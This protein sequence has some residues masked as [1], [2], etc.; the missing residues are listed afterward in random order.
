[1]NKKGK[2]LALAMTLTLSVRSDAVDPRRFNRGLLHRSR[3][4]KRTLAWMRAEAK[5]IRQ[6]VPK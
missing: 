4:I 2:L 5:N 3:S 1:M 6:A